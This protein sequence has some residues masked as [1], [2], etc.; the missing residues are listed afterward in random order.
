MLYNKHKMRNKLVIDNHE[1]YFH[2]TFKNYAGSLDGYVIHTLNQE[3]TLGV[4]N[5]KGFMVMTV[6]EDW[7]RI[8]VHDF[9]WECFHGLMHFGEEVIHLNKKADDNR[10]NNLKLRN[11]NEIIIKVTPNGNECYA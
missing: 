3:P 11:S 9:I 5:E 10:L 8:F 1:Y 4:K 2:P 6:E 7:H